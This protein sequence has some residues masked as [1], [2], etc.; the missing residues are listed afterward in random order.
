MNA[1]SKDESY[2]QQTWVERLKKQTNKEREKE[3]KKE[4]ERERKNGLPNGKF[5]TKIK[6]CLV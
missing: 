2:N 3:R 6:R 5:E 4:R 1:V